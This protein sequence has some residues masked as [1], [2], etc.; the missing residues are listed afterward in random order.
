MKKVISVT[1]LEMI[2]TWEVLKNAWINNLAYSLIRQPAVNS[3]SK[4]FEALLLMVAFDKSEYFQTLAKPLIAKAKEALK[5]VK[6]EDQ[7]IIMDENNTIHRYSY[8]DIAPYLKTQIWMSEEKLTYR[9]DKYPTKEFLANKDINR[10]V[11][12]DND[13]D[14]WKSIDY[15][16]ENIKSELPWVKIENERYALDDIKEIWYF[17]NYLVDENKAYNVYKLNMERI[18][19]NKSSL[20]NKTKNSGAKKADPYVYRKKVLNYTETSKR[21]VPFLIL[22]PILTIAFLV[23]DLNGWSYSSR[24]TW[25]WTTSSSYR[26][27]NTYIFWS[28]GWGG[29]SSYSSS[30]SSSSSSFVRSFWWGGFSKW[31]S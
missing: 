16:L 17:E 4:T 10:I 11:V 30:S 15:Y 26:S 18:A 7:Y 19:A 13:S 14:A 2:I 8:H 31:S 24:K 6:C 5:N 28:F 29:W 25:T 23:S 22:F 20:E 12:M 27:S 9:I 21:I 1:P 3:Y